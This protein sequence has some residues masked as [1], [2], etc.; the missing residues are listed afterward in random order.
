MSEELDQQI[1]KAQADLETAWDE[2]ANKMAET[3]PDMKDEIAAL[4]AKAQLQRQQ[5]E[6]LVKKCHPND[7][8]WPPNKDCPVCQKLLERVEN[9][10]KQRCTNPDDDAELQEKFDQAFEELYFKREE[11]NK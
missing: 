3:C 5:R 11:P 2:L 7:D 4:R 10:A 9:V 1:E 8:H 6:E